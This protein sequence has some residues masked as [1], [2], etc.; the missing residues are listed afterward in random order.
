MEHLTS[1]DSEKM[2]HLKSLDPEK[3]EHLKSLVSEEVFSKENKTITILARGEF[4]GKY[5]IKNMDVCLEPLIEELQD[6]WRGI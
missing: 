3:M 1:L 5:K 2:E 6:I 4:V